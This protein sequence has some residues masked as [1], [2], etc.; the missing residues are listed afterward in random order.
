MQVNTNLNTASIAKV[1]TEAPVRT[2]PA[3]P[4][5]ETEFSATDALNNALDQTPDVRPDAV[6]R[7]ANLVSDKDYPPLEIIRR[8][9]RLFA[10]GAD[11]AGE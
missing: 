7:A 11:N 10:R 9:S 5:S 4:V 6:A 3:R 8:L 2:A 1:T